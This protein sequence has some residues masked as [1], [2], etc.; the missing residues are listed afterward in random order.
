MITP[1]LLRTIGEALYGPRWQTDLA[2]DLAVSDRTVR[3]WVAGTDAL[4]AGVAADLA[5]LCE[6]RA[7]ILCKLRSHLTPHHQITGSSS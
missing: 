1:D 4:P 6:E 7:R 3:R 5:R 2:R